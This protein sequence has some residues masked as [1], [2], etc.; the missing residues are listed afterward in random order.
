MISLKDIKM[1]INKKYVVFGF[2]FGVLGILS[3]VI[4]TQHGVVFSIF[5]FALSYFI[6]IYVNSFQNDFGGEF[7]DETKVSDSITG[8]LTHNGKSKLA[9]DK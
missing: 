5:F 3:P 8:I 6:A 1:V 4:S 9:L 7:R 2:V